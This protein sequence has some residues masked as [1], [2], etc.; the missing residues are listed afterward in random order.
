MAKLLRKGT[1]GLPEEVEVATAGAASANNGVSSDGTNV[2]LGQAVGQ[3]GDPAKLLS[4][5]EIP[6]DGKSVTF[7]EKTSGQI[8][9]VRL[10]GRTGDGTNRAI[11]E[12]SNG[13][14]FNTAAN[15]I[16]QLVHGTDKN[17][18]VWAKDGTNGWKNVATFE[19]DGDLTLAKSLFI[20]Q[21]GQVG[22]SLYEIRQDPGDGQTDVL[23]IR[24]SGTSS[25]GGADPAYSLVELDAPARA[26]NTDPQ[27]STLTLTRKFGTRNEFLDVFNNGYPSGTYPSMDMG[28]RV[29]KRGTGVLRPLVI[30]FASDLASVVDA[31]RITPLTVNGAGVVTDGEVTFKAPFR[32]VLAN[33]LGLEFADGDSSHRITLKAP[34]TVPNS[35][36]LNL[37]TAPP[38]AGQALIASSATQLSWGSAGSSAESTTYITTAYT[39]QDTDFN[40]LFNFPSNL[41]ITLPTAAGRAGKKFTFKKIFGAGNGTIIPNGAEQIDGGANQVIAATN[42]AFTIISDGANWFVI[43]RVQNASGA[44]YTA[45]SVGTTLSGVVWSGTAPTS[46]AYRH[47]WSRVGN[48]TTVEIHGFGTAAQTS[49]GVEFDLPA[50]CPSPDEWYT[51]LNAQFAVATAAFSNANA[52]TNASRGGMTKISTG[53][54]WRVSLAWAST[55]VRYF[56]CT[57]TYRSV[58]GTGST[59]Q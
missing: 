57:I 27:E 30:Q 46:I 8:L 58:P 48:L 23:L 18:Y 1:D 19:P 36:T 28:L 32:P 54:G 45:S 12:F 24:R 37:P 14:T 55:A 49:T 52:V 21:D 29:Q 3:L 47:R 4:S 9:L 51:T 41:S 11:L 13:A 5:R 59:E 22:N 33:A 2:V 43:H 39:V 53:S 35:Y 26:T 20:K 10:E 31:L 56:S 50:N 17:L 34:A 42:E 6:T 25:A 7:V 15:G 38:T 40:I 44:L 16:F